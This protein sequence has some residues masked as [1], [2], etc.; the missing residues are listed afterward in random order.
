MNEKKTKK[1]TAIKERWDNS[2]V[3]SRARNVFRSQD[4]RDNYQRAVSHE[5]IV[6]RKVSSS[7]RLLIG[8]DV[9][10]G[11]RPTTADGLGR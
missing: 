8:I 4:A 10:D 7:L 2:T 3:R 1:V 9:D 5:N 6:M 11:P